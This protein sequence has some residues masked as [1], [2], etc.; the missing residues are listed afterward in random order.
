MRRRAAWK[1]QQQSKRKEEGRQFLQRGS[2]RARLYPTGG[3][4]ARGVRASRRSA[5]LLQDVEVPAAAAAA[6]A[7]GVRMEAVLAAAAAVTGVVGVVKGRRLECR[8]RSRRRPGQPLRRRAPRAA[9]QLH[10][11]VLVLVV[12][13]EVVLIVVVDVSGDDGRGTQADATDDD[14]LRIDA[15]L[16]QGALELVV[17]FSKFPKKKTRTTPV[18]ERKVRS[19]ARSRWWKFYDQLARQ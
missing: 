1:R 12:V 3:T 7:A 10:V 15:Q 18:K 9:Q 2:P 6:A 14:G 19:L 17:F 5:H 13:A 8:V 16:S 4:G 11:S